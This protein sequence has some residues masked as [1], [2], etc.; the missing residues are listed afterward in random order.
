MSSI[1]GVVLVEP[2]YLQDRR[3]FAMVVLTFR[4]G[5]EDEEVMGLKF[6]TEAILDYRQVRAKK[7][8]GDPR[9]QNDQ[10][11]SPPF[12]CYRLERC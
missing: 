9:I 2:G 7:P 3:V 5:R 8:T 6:Y 10:N 4:Y 1:D 11:Y 12:F